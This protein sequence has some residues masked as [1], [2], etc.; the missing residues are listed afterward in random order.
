MLEIK[1][2]CTFVVC[3]KMN[4]S[5]QIFAFIVLFI[6]TLSCFGQRY[7]VGLNGGASYYLGDINPGKHFIESEYTYGLYGRYN[8]N[9]RISL[10]LSGNYAK[11]HSSDQTSKEDLVRNAWFQS[12]FIDVSAMC[13]INFFP[14]FIGA[15]REICTPY[16]TG[17]VS[18]AIPLTIEGGFLDDTYTFDNTGLYGDNVSLDKKNVVAPNLAIGFGVK[19]SLSKRFGVQV[20]WV[21]HKTF[22]D[23]LD[24][25]YYYGNEEYFREQ[26]LL[27]VCNKSN[28]DWYSALQLGVSYKFETRKQKKCVEHLQNF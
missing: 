14:F 16:L 19:F 26:N 6:T 18:V 3:K 22:A 20:E 4:N 25:I 17:G 9:K 27:Y 11:I 8:F 15:K 28:M 2:D 10:K 12:D 1:K 13:E 24:G 7:E 21:M 5:K 23:W